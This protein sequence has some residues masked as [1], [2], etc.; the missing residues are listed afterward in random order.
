METQSM[1]CELFPRIRHGAMEAFVQSRKQAL[2]STP[3]FS[4]ATIHSTSSTVQ[5]RPGP[6]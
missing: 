2:T 5:R 1:L 6:R 3:G 4:V